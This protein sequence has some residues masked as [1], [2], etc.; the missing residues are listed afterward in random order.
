MKGDFVIKFLEGLG[1]TVV[2]IGTTWSRIPYKGVRYSDFNIYGYNSRKKYVGFKNLERR[3]FIKNKGDDYFIFTKRG[4]DWLQRS[5][6]KH[7]KIKTGGKWDKKWRVIIFDI[8]QELHK[9]RVK[10]R[11]KL[12]SLGFAALQKSVLV[13]PYPCEEEVGDICQKLGVGDYIDVLVA[14][15][16]G[17]KEGEFLKIFNL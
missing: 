4:Q 5:F 3:G 17:S 2:D 6:I 15:S 10:L 12:Q 16:I 9:E 13:F 14:E 11:K 8:P 1:E 7:T